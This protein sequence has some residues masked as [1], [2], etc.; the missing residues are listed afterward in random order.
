MRLFK[1]TEWTYY[2]LIVLVI[3]ATIDSSS[4]ALKWY[5]L[6]TDDRAVILAKEV[7]MLA[8]PYPQ[9]TA[10]FKL[11]EGAIIHHERSEDGWCLIHLSSERRG[12]IRS[13]DMEQVIVT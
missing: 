13:Q 9:D 7:D 4:L 3:F 12:W 10:L 5:Q 1:K 2:L 6:K 8:G 11:H